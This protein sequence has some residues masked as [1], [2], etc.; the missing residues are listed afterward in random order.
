MEIRA[1]LAHSDFAKSRFAI[2]LLAHESLCNAVIHGNQRDAD[3]T[4]EVEMQ[5][6]RA[7]V[8]L[9]VTDEGAGFAWRTQSSLPPDVD[10]TS[11]RGLPL[12]TLF[13]KRIRF[14]DCGNRITLWIRK[15]EKS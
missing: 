3:K 13:A 12:Y 1:L 8:R 4:V 15:N 9:Q 2:E 10:S 7:W 5:M 14:N 11:G 6:R